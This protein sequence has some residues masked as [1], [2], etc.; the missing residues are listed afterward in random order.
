MS[1]LRLLVLASGGL[2]APPSEALPAALAIDSHA[3][4]GGLL[5]ALRAGDC[6][7]VL[8]RLPAPEAPGREAAL[9][10]LAELAERQ[11]APGLLCWVDAHDAAGAALC[12]EHGAEQVLVGAPTPAEW[13]QRLSAGLE[14]CLQERE[15][16]R[17]RLEDPRGPLQRLA[18][19][20]A[21]MVQLRQRLLEA[22]SAHPAT[23]L[24]RGEPGAGQGLAARALHELAP[25]APGPFL[26]WEAAGADAERQA[27]VL[28]GRTPGVCA[29]TL[30]A[31]R[32]GS[33]FLEGLEALAP[34]LQ[35]RLQRWLQERRAERPGERSG[36]GGEARLLAAAE[37]DLEAAVAAGRLRSDLYYR[38]NVLELWL[39]PLRE[40]PE[41]LGLLC[42]EILGRL[43][44]ELGTEA[45]ELDPGALAALAAEPWPGNLREL[46]QRLRRAALLAAGP[47]LGPADLSPGPRSR[48]AEAAPLASLTLAEI[49]RDQ[50]QRVLQEC[51]HNKSLAAR[52]LGLHRSTLYAKLRELPV[53]A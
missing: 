33:L 26:H 8:L 40:R 13:R 32:G 46:E 21:A 50:I 6:E 15:R 18:G 43:S 7:L 2:E 12:F 49:E 45:L 39:P 16:W 14:R 9:G 5:A 36:P 34:A 25:R 53:G 41:D 23:V 42:A 3:D 51:G 19:T 11:P 1:A 20:S 31:A 38:L 10:L 44:R 17:A 4:A 22:A 29:G 48:R 28:F 27:A 24:I 52:R 37:G 35:A 47:V 30:A